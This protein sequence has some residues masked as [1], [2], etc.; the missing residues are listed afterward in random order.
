MAES[1]SPLYERDVRL[2]YLKVAENLGGDGERVG[3][4]FLECFKV[5]SVS[6]DA[7]TV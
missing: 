4:C 1:L 7:K 5:S 6:G 2:M 3:D